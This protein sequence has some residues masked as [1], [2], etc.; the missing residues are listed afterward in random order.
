MSVL[1]LFSLIIFFDISRFCQ[2]SSVSACKLF[3]FSFWASNLLTCLVAS[4]KL[5]DQ[6]LFYYA[7]GSDSYLICL[8]H[9]SYFWTIWWLQRTQHLKFVRLLAGAAAT[10]LD[11][12]SFIQ[13]C[14]SKAGCEQVSPPLRKPEDLSLWRFSAA[15]LMRSEAW[16]WPKLRWSPFFTLGLK[17]NFN[18]SFGRWYPVAESINEWFM[19][20]GPLKHATIHTVTLH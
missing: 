3:D 2:E 4:L 7:H 11:T 1:L 14:L 15:H 13:H 10:N 16:V 18:W 5:W 12:L 8:Y 17:T 9:C 19:S 20:S 6:I